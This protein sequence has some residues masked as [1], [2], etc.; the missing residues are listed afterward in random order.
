MEIIGTYIKN[1]WIIKPKIFNDN[2][3]SFLKT[4]NYD[5]FKYH[6]LETDFKESYYSI[7]D[8]NVIRGM[9]FQIPPKDHTKL[10]YVSSGKIL[11]VVLDIRKDSLTYGEYF[12]IEIS[13]ENGYVLYIPSGLA[14]GF[15]SLSDNTIANYMQTS[16][17]DSECDSGIKF[18]SFNMKWEIENPI[19]SNRDLS[20]KNFN[21]FNSLF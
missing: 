11:D 8:K 17:Y 9:H 16:T 13:A 7:S 14:H 6:N 15:L 20:F 21:D 18:D 4:F 3:G 2:R 5:F 12:S 1:L 19:V 10:V